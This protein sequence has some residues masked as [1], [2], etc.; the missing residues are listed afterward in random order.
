MRCS[1]I[2]EL[3]ELRPTL[4]RIPNDSAVGGGDG[5]LTF[6]GSEVCRQGGYSSASPFLRVLRS[7]HL[8]I[9][10]RHMRSQHSGS[11]P[12]DFVRAADCLQQAEHSN[13]FFCA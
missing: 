9:R 7:R 3:R 6:V 10:V 13:E 2:I 8:H 5:G 12:A 11:C 1:S 4:R